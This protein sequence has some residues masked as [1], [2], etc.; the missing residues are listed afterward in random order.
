MCSNHIGHYKKHHTLLKINLSKKIQY[1]SLLSRVMT[2][3]VKIIRQNIAEHSNGGALSFR[4]LILSVKLI[5]QA[6]W[7]E[8]KM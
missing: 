7:D 5:L 4:E 6:D 1:I 8:T 2:I 3:Y